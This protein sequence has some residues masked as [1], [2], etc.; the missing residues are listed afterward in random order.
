[1]LVLS[2]DIGEWVI[3]NDDIKLVIVDIQK[4]RVRLGIEAPKD[5][6][7]HRKEIY[8]AIKKKKAGEKDNAN[9]TKNK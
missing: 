1:M 8:D 5:T 3:I 2:R 4:D 6:T 7:I 9:E